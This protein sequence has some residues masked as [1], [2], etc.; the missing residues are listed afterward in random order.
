M[1]GVAKDPGSASFMQSEWWGEFKS[2]F[3]WRRFLHRGSGGIP[4]LV[5][6]RPL[7]P[8]FSLAYVPGGPPIDPQDPGA[9]VTLGAIAEEIAH[10]AS[11][12]CAFVRFDLPW[13][14]ADEHGGNIERPS[15]PSPFKKASTDVQPPDTVLVDL[16]GGEEAVLAGM[17]PK[18]RYNVKLAEKRGVT[19]DSISASNGAIDAIPEFYSLY[20][21]TS[22][23]DGISLHPEAYYRTQFELAR[24]H[25]IDLRLWFA[26]HEGQTLASIITVFHAGVATYLYGAS[27]NEKRN[28]MPAYALQWAA[29]GSAIAVGCESYDFYGIPPTSDEG[30]PMHGLY[31]FKTGFGGVVAHRLGSW[32]FV[33]RPIAY[34]LWSFAEQARWW[35]HKR[36]KKRLAGR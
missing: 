7:A 29:I 2:R 9:V 22:E 27:S 24:E 19:V 23:R 33:K 5:L 8:G 30:H 26:R 6:E 20:K 11:K 25:G 16:R 4:T 15:L 3:G 10:A 21:T 1:T 31:Q 18:W 35:Y 14:R 17:K 34:A 12:S 32:D 36:L 13:Y 28:L